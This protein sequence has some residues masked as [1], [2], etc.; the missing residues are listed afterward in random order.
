M[1]WKSFRVLSE[2]GG[3]TN[4]ES[5][6]NL[7]LL[8]PPG[9]F[10]TSWMVDL[11]MKCFSQPMPKYSYVEVACNFSLVR[12]K[13]INRFR[14]LLKIWVER[15][16]APSLFAE[17]MYIYQW[18]ALNN[19]RLKFHQQWILST[20]RL[21]TE[22]KSSCHDLIFIISV[23]WPS[24]CIQNYGPDLSPSHCAIVFRDTHIA[25]LMYA[26][27]KNSLHK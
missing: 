24:L 10:T 27:D 25:W 12:T 16:Q 13:C 14:M 23:W 19:F 4:Y 9:P 15:K 2:S 11:G 5:L 22:F 18:H 7:L 21:A 20:H 17:N 3:K 6:I 26:A 8:C 1:H